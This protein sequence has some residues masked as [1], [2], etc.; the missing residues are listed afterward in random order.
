[1]GPAI[2]GRCYEVGPEVVQ[3]VQGR[4]VDGPA[5][6]DL[7]AALGS[8][9]ERAGVQHVTASEFCTRCHNERFFSHRA[10]DAGRHIAVIARIA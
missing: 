5:T 9:L 3:A 7:R 6:V 2:C 1:M 10:G 4:L 8:Q